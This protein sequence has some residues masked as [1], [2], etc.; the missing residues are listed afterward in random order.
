MALLLLPFCRWG[1]RHRAVSTCRTYLRNVSCLSICIWVQGSSSHGMKMDRHRLWRA[2]PVSS[3]GWFRHG[4]EWESGFSPRGPQIRHSRP[5]SCTASLCGVR[6]LS[7][8]CW[9][10]PEMN[11]SGLFLALPSSLHQQPH[12]R[13]LAGWGYLPAN[14]RCVLNTLPAASSRPAM[15]AQQTSLI[16]LILRLG[17]GPQSKLCSPVVP[18]PAPH[19]SLHSQPRWPPP[20]S[21]LLWFP[22]HLGY[23]RAPSPV[24]CAIQ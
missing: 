15:F 22:S 5:P 10:S 4:W 16:S 14:T 6:P 1:N 23:R 20:V 12:R 3:P 11:P 17:W 13:G 9:Y 19:P 21:P 2:S 18:L 8:P 7:L 24:P